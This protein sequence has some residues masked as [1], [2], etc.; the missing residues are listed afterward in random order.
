M[1]HWQAPFTGGFHCIPPRGEVV[2][3][4]DDPPPSSVAAACRPV[5]YHELE[6]ALVPY[7]DR[8][9]AKYDGYTLVIPFE[10]FGRA[11][12]RLEPT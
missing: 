1:T 11:L 12:E 4:I 9:S 7:D 6:S 3:V 2:T 8:I 10:E 5:R